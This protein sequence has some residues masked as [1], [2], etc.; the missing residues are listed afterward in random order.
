[1]EQADSSR[2]RGA[3]LRASESSRHELCTCIPCAFLL[4]PKAFS[5]HPSPPSH[6]HP[7]CRSACASRCPLFWH[8]LLS[9]HPLLTCLSC[10]PSH[11]FRA[12]PP[13]PP[14]LQKRMSGTL[15]ADQAQHVP[16]ILGAL[17]ACARFS[18]D[19]AAYEAEAA[20]ATE[21]WVAG[22]RAAQRCAR[23]STA[24][25]S[26]FWA[27]WLGLERCAKA[28]CLGG[29]NWCLKWLAWVGDQAHLSIPNEKMR[30][31]L[32]GS[33]HTF[34]HP[35]FNRSLCPELCRVAAAEEESAVSD[36]R[37]DL[38]T[39]FKNTAKLVPGEVR[40]AALCP[41]VALFTLF[42]THSLASARRGELRCAA[43]C[44]AVALFTLLKNKAKL[45]LGK[46]R[47]ASLC[48]A[49][50]L[51]STARVA[52]AQSDCTTVGPSPA[53][54]TALWAPGSRQCSPQAPSVHEPH[55]STSAYRNPHPRPAG[56]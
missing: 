45:V 44:P 8:A 32:F 51:Y 7:S 42:K 17:A 39:L 35:L 18:D 41:A 47:C 53:R 23:R 16:A 48:H 29:E 19:S 9:L 26:V 50:V 37:Q 5:C 28:G 49:A 14:P 31:P 55:F 43:F 34:S 38:F 25:R 36:R 56:L 46:V 4:W 10:H 20:S 11:A 40:C 12:T 54:P 52:E 30:A 1:M 27:S 24:Q 33:C 6:P 22:A 13:S 2:P 21:R 3:G 15:P